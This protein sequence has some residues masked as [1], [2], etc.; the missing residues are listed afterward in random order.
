MVIIIYRILLQV[1]VPYVR[2]RVRYYYVSGCNLATGDLKGICSTGTWCMGT[3]TT[4]SSKYIAFNSINI[5]CYNEQY[6]CSTRDA[7]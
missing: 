6:R 1:L 2:L 7:C 4:S 5:V 3:S